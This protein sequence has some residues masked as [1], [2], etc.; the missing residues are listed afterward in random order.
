MYFPGGFSAAVARKEGSFFGAL[1]GL[2]LF[3]GLS[4]KSVKQADFFE[5]TLA[6]VRRIVYDNRA[7]LF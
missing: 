2:R 4:K 7:R 1:S 5:K 3:A 6:I